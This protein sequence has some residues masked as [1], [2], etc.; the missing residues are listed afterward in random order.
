MAN[1]ISRPR[2]KITLATVSHQGF[3]RILLPAQS[4]KREWGLPFLI[5][6]TPQRLP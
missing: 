1:L 4:G 6:S 2:L 5:A 3:Q